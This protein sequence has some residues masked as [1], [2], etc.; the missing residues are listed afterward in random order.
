MQGRYVKLYIATL[1]S[2]S[3]SRKA[4]LHGFNNF[5]IGRAVFGHFSTYR[6]R[7][8][9]LFVVENVAVLFGPDLNARLLSKHGG[10]LMSP[11]SSSPIE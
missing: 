5:D 7:L 2:H 8:R 11:S 10:E 1:S 6:L 9:G 4:V 3:R